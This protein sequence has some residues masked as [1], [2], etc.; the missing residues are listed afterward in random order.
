[1]TQTLAI[2]VDA[3]RELNARKLFW[4]TLILSLVVVLAFGLVGVTPTGLKII[5]W[6]LESE[7]L[8]SRFIKP[9]VFYKGLF[10]G[11]GI[12]FW[13][14][15]LASILA[16]VS[17]ASI[18]PDLIGSG[19]IDLVL[20][21]P[22]GRLRLFLTKFLGGLLFVA[23]QVT[24][25]AVACFVVIGLRGG[26]WEPGLLLSIPIVL[27][28]FSYLFS[29][30]VLFGMITRS[31]IA[32]LLLTL[33]VWFLIFGLHTA[34]SAVML[35]RIGADLRVESVQ[36]DLA[37]TQAAATQPV[38]DTASSQIRKQTAESRLKDLTTEIAAAHAGQSRWTTVHRIL[39][40]AKTIF[41]KTSE[42][43]ELLERWLIDTA[44][45]PEPEERESEPLTFGDRSGRVS[46]KKIHQQFLQEIRS[47]SVY[48]VL[49]TSFLFE[50]VVVGLAAWI[51]CRRDY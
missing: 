19:S 10:T 25:F 44:D 5:V 22:I 43:V 4:L 45:L 17:T 3:Y 28:F 41:P 18:F 9:D 50:G 51:F 21:K 14:G 40:G 11:F 37:R 24:V 6:D 38:D 35:G 49:G 20:S 23:L 48:W 36:K 15:W 1:M 31:T 7:V 26:V 2:L 29:V 8:N 32:S 47:R 42:T 33:L 16:L 39:F 27:G 46:G 30:M 34:E 13:L 12:K